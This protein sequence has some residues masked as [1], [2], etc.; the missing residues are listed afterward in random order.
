MHYDRF[1]RLLHLLLALGI[2]VELLLAAVMVH[3]KPGRAGDVFY[4]LHA[5]LGQMILGVLLV[6]WLWSLAR[7]GRRPFALLVPWF[8]GERRRA[9]WS[10]LGRHLVHARQ[11]RLPPDEGE[12]APLAGAV[13]GA[14]L[15]VATLMGGSGIVL[16]VVD[17]GLASRGWAHALKE[18]HEAMGP[19]MWGYL[20]AHALMAVMH[21]LAG[22]PGVR[23]MVRV[24][25]K[26]GAAA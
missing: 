24:W 22:H 2:S 15:L 10:D 7:P 14:G 26:S 16:L 17:P 12:P 19:L 8:S 25:E 5:N 20:A 21:R 13:H 18:F 1:T 3:P 9:V 11:G 6:H 4:A 23:P